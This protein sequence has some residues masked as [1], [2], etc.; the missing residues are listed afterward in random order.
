MK[1]AY[2]NIMAANKWKR[3]IYFTSPY[4]ELGFQQYL[5][6]DGLTYR[7]VPVKNSEVNRDWA[8]DVMMKKFVFGNADKPGVYYDEENRRHLNTI[9]MQYAQVAAITWLIMTGKM[10]QKNYWKDAIK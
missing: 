4:D 2:L 8:Y 1:A 9:R 10:M 5:R 3:P 6:T 7:L